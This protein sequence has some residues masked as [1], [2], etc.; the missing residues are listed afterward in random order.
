MLI[1][2]NVVARCGYSCIR[3]HHSTDVLQQRVIRN[4][5]IVSGQAGISLSSNT[6]ILNNI[7]I[8]MLP[9]TNAISHDPRSVDGKFF[10]SMTAMQ[11]YIHTYIQTYAHTHTDNHILTHTHTHP[12]TH[13]HTHTY[14][15]THKSTNAHTN[16]IE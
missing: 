13:R 9:T 16:T 1:E 3:T 10:I 7:A 15:Y 8:M 6:M 12:F 14:T 11:T 4:L 2:D 5:V